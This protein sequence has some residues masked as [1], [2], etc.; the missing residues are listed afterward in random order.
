MGYYKLNPASDYY[1]SSLSCNPNEFDDFFIYPNPSN[2]N[3]NITMPESE[4]YIIKIVNVNGEL[5]F[6]DNINTMPV[7]I[8]ISEKPKGLYF[9]T[10]IGNENSKNEILVIQ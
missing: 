9:L 8:D 10:I 5:V 1:D 7:N 4:Q 3:F 6:E 2:G